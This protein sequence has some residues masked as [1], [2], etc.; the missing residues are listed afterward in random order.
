[1]NVIVCRD[2]EI[3]LYKLR[4][5]RFLLPQIKFITL[6]KFTF[7]L[8]SASLKLACISALQAE[9]VPP[10]S[11]SLSLSLFESWSD[12]LVRYNNFAVI[13]R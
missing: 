7:L 2:L 3:S 11:L 6:H 9:K 5:F 12:F 4:V 10:L 8:V 13:C 1:M